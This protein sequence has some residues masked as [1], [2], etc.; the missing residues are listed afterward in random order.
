[1]M[2]H[3]SV[4]N[5]MWS[6]AVCTIVYLRNRTFSRAVHPL[7]GVPLTLLT[8]VDPNASKFRVF[9]CTF[10]A[11]VPNLRKLGE[12]AFRGVMVGYS[13]DVLGYR[14][15]NLVPRRMTT[16]V[17]V[18]F[19][20]TVP[21]FHVSHWID[22]LIS[23]ATDAAD[24]F[25]LSR[26]ILLDTFDIDDGP[27]LLDTNRPTRLRSRPTKFGEYVAHLS[28]YPPVFVTVCCDP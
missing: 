16:S 24:Q 1:M 28:A 26:V 10:F 13:F 12:R 3:M 27:L 17:H 25:P 9:G 8:Q 4:P 11:K 21:G 5:F 18:M 14:A 6:C 23:D 2:H 22:S 15:Y 7:G 20:Q 19:K